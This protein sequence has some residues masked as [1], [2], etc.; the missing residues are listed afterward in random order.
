MRRTTT[1]VF[2]GAGFVKALLVVF[3]VLLAA[4]TSFASVT[5][6]S[7]NSKG[8]LANISYVKFIAVSDDG[9]D[10]SCSFV[11][12]QANYGEIS[13]VKSGEETA[14]VLR[15]SL[16]GVSNY[17]IKCVE[18]IPPAPVVEEIPAQEVVEEVP[19]VEQ[20][21]PMPL[22]TVEE[23]DITGDHNVDSAQETVESAPV[24]TEV[25]V[26][27]AVVEIIQ[28]VVDVVI[29]EEAVAVVE[30]P[31]EV[32]E[33]VAVEPVV[34]EQPAEVVAEVPAEEAVVVETSVEETTEQP[35]EVVTSVPVDMVIEQPVEVVA[36]EET[37]V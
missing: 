26:I 34:V 28:D 16:R 32:A 31:V 17:N 27:D 24:E 11:I 21:Q 20:P 18:I 36:V 7:L 6:T 10:M 1:N 30:A 25:T 4:S 37:P 15:N 33:E 2:K 14:L 23:S 19:I 3:L 29:G 13:P 12:G 22:T 8:V 5:V 35:I 9:Y